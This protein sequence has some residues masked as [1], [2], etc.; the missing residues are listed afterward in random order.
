MS[1]EEEVDL[2]IKIINHPAG[3]DVAIFGLL[4][5]RSHCDGYEVACEADATHKDFTNLVDAAQFFVDKR[6][7]LELGLDIEA[8]L[9][10][11]ERDNSKRL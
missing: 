7:E 3:F 5:I 2:I 9:M 4:T 10:K 1:K 11:D 8:K 6:H